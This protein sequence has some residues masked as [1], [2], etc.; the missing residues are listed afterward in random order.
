MLSTASAFKKAV[1]AIIS[2]PRMHLCLPA[3]IIAARPHRLQ[4]NP[5]QDIV[6]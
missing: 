4:A 1:D 6:L 5:L 2:P 3:D